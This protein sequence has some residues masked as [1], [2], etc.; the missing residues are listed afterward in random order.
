MHYSEG[1]TRQAYLWLGV[2]SGRP[3][4][5][6]SAQVSRERAPLSP[7]VFLPLVRCGVWP[8]GRQ[9]VG[10]GVTWTG[11][12]ITSRLLTFGWG[13]V[14]GRPPGCRPRCHGAGPRPHQSSSYLWLGVVSGRP[15]GR[16]GVGPGVTGPGPTI[17]SRLLT[18]GWV[19]CLAGRPPGCRPRCHGAGPRPH[20]SSSPRRLQG[21]QSWHILPR[22]R[23]THR[24][25]MELDLQRLIGLLCTVVLIGWDPR[26]SPPS[27]PPLGSDMRGAINQPR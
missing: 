13:V 5:R 19:W 27:P 12:T 17:T 11:P 23:S 8:A 14:S 3:A 25:N 22:Y 2:V 24:S 9:G 20:Q 16:Q 26:K 10:P 21:W 15:A 18:F 4:A 7:V 6:V 1:L